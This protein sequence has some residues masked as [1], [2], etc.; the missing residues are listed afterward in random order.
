MSEKG[1]SER[2]AVTRFVKDLRAMQAQ[3]PGSTLMDAYHQVL[4]DTPKSDYWTHIASLAGRYNITH[5]HKRWAISQV[6]DS[7]SAE[8]SYKNAALASPKLV[9]ILIKLDAKDAAKV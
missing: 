5:P 4:R 3:R 2:E 7:M 1:L 8:T 9:P 6:L